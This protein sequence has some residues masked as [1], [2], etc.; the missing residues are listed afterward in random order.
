MHKDAPKAAEAAACANEQGKFWEMHD[1]LFANAP[2]LQILDLKRYATE[3][4]LQT[5]RFDHCLDAGKYTAKWQ[6]DKVEG[7]S[8]GV[9]GT[10][11]F[12]INGRMVGGA[13]PYEDFAEMIEEE[14][15][16]AATAPKSR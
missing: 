16:R 3:I 7:S 13:V 12:F 15:Q 2:K 14:L 11:A 5:D 9:S 4:G 8:Y 10:P 6:G 1:K